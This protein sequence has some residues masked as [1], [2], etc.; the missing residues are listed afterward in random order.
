MSSTRRTR[1]AEW[2]LFTRSSM[3]PRRWRLHVDHRV[4]SSYWADHLGERVYII[5]NQDDTQTAWMESTYVRLLAM[6]A[7][8]KRKHRRRR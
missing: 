7:A 3:Q 2:R 6:R 5:I 4:R 1:A 8:P